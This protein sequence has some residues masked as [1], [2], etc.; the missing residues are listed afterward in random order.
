MVIIY[1]QDFN[2]VES[3]SRPQTKLKLEEYIAENKIDY[4][5]E[6]RL[7][8]AR[9]LIKEQK[10]AAAI[11]ELKE[12]IELNYK[13][14][15][16]NELLGDICL[17]YLR[18]NEK[19]LKYFEKS[20]EL[21]FNNPTCAYKAARIYFSQQNNAQGLECIKAVIENTD[22]E[23]ILNKT[24]LLLTNAVKAKKPELNPEALA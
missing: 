19:A 15:I 5:N 3:K 16:C 14:N 12:L 13:E 7:N 23:N 6:F 4:S 8:D 18:D 17:K 1:L 11:Y 9:R 2:M 22:D 21:E 20:L 24:I 10:Y